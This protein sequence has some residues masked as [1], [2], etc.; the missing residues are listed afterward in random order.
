M[1]ALV[2]VGGMMVPIVPVPV[3]IVP[4]PEPAGGAEAALLVEI[5]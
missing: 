5:V 1:G 2:V 4:V 3:P